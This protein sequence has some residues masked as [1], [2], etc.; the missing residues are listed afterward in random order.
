M[1]DDNLRRKYKPT[2]GIEC[3]VQFKT[4]TKL[5]SGV[6]NDAREAPPNTLVSHICFGLPGALP[7]LN[8][9]AVHLAT[10]ASFVLGTVPEHYST[11]DR[12]HYFYPDL[13]KGYQ[14]TQFAQPIIGKGFIK[15]EVDGI[16]KT[17]G[18]TRAHLEEDAGKNI[19]P[20]GTDYSLVDLN[21]AGTPLLEIVSEPDIHSAAEAKAYARELYLGMK[22]ADVS[23]ANLYYGNMRFDV[24]V[25]VSQTDELGTRTETKNLNSFRAVEKAIEY[26]I[27]RQIEQLEKGNKIIQETLGWDEAKQK[28]ISQRSKEEAQDYRYFPEPDIPPIVIDDEYIEEIRKE[29][30]IMPIEWRHRLKNL[31]IDQAYIETL[32]DAEADSVD[33]GYMSLIESAI[34][35]ADK[36]TFFASWQ[37]NIEIPL[38][39]PND[40]AT[41]FDLKT[42]QH[43]FNSVYSLMKEN[44]LNSSRAKELLTLLL[45][46][47]LIP[48]NIESL[49]I[50][51]GFIQVSDEAELTNV[52][53]E[54]IAA[55][56]QAANDVKNGE[57]QAIG[58]L[59]GKVMQ[60]TK[61][62]A[63]PELTQKIIR[64]KLGV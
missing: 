9:E 31:G 42:K 35:D 11:F 50:D 14:I 43:I 30:P 17:I 24:N 32:L 38:R 6:N 25:S 20:A 34:N 61:G 15:I 18:V 26:E 52:I 27:N 16:E 28:T 23:D 49:A 46:S 33:A 57:T 29:L 48:D 53:V 7:V 40:K 58:F 44:K 21:R 56:E 41:T 55:N 59:V 51:K 1:I 13:P 12:K 19:H 62:R 5:F 63:N 36:A 22:F 10:K 64:D 39:K 8:K 47:E 37:V 4:L 45:N 3:H 54:I 60:A 2:I